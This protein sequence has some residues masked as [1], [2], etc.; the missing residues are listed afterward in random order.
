M[1]STTRS[2]TFTFPDRKE[3]VRYEHPS[4]AIFD[5][6]VDTQQSSVSAARTMLVKACVKSHTGAQ[7]DAIFEKYPM[8]KHSIAQAIVKDAGATID[9]VEG[10]QPAS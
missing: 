3:V 4:E 2:L 9:M 7:L 10:E 5:R 8:V 1:D 6:F